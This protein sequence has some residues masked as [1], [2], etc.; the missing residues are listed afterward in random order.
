MAAPCIHKPNTVAVMNRQPTTI[1]YTVAISC[2]G[3]NKY[4][5]NVIVE[6]FKFNARTTEYRVT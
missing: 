3:S 2:T 1:Y 4:H 5:P 6:F